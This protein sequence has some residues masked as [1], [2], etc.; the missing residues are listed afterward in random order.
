MGGSILR[1][2]WIF[3]FDQHPLKIR[4]MGTVEAGG[5]T[6]SLKGSLE[7]TYD[8]LGQWR[9]SGEYPLRSNPQAFSA[10]LEIQNLP[11]EKG[12]PLLV[13]SPL[14]SNHPFLGKISLQG[15]LN[16]RLRV[17]KKEEAFQIGGRLT[18]SNMTLQIQD[19]SLSFNELSLDI[20]FFLSPSPFESGR[21]L[22]SES[23][24]IQM[25]SEKG[26]HLAKAGF[27]LSILAKP[28]LFE[29]LDK[30]EIPLWG[31]SVTLPSLKLSDPLGD[32]QITTALSLKDLNLNR[33]LKIQGISGT[34][35]GQLDPLVINQKK[36]LTEGTLKAAIFE[37][38]VEGKN[39]TMLTPFSSDRRLQGDLF[40]S[41]F[42]LESITKLFSFGRITGFVQGEL[43]GLSIWYNQPEK[44][45]LLIKTQEISGVSK[46]IHI[47]AIE[48]I[49]LLGTGW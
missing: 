23:G 38:I 25:N 41:H 2:P 29:V 32:F 21:P 10:S 17:S 28:N 35:N 15:L 43:T 42:N 4:G 26:P 47:K 6:G 37:G 49:S 44:F 9:V 7:L 20:P 13:G 16:A 34:L 36:V 45:N 19:P 39:L 46:S 18:G 27:S 30:I 11:T 14:S 33:L 8:P 31:G 12:Y 22:F 3:G 48:N 1:S 40:F 5:Q 24:F